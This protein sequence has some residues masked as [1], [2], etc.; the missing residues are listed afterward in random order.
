[1]KLNRDLV[2][3]GNRSAGVSSRYCIQTF[4]K[5]IPSGQS[6]TFKFEG[7]TTGWAD[8]NMGGY[9]SQ[10]QAAFHYAVKMGGYMTQTYT[11]GWNVQAEWTRNTT[12]T[13]T[14]NSNNFTVVI[15]NNATSQPMIVMVG[16]QS[17]VEAFTCTIT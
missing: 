4:Y 1:M 2:I 5:N 3:T 16:T 17:S 7:M 15:D 9:A 6:A 14:Q 12:I 13:D 11:W 10:G 8:V